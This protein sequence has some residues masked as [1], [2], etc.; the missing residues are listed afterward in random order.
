MRK[1]DLTGKVFHKLTVLEDTGEVRWK[2]PLW[3]CVCECGSTA[4]VT[5]REL[6]AGYVKSCGC[7]KYKSNPKYKEDLYKEW[8]YMKGRC[9][10]NQNSEFYKY[11]AGRGVRVCEEW[12]DDYEA[13]RE[14][15]LA[16]NYKEGLE[17]DRYPDR[18]GDYSPTNCRWV[19]HKENMRNTRRNRR[20][21]AFAESKA[22]S[23][24]SEE[25]DIN[26]S[27]LRGRIEGGWTTE[28]ALQEPVRQHKKYSLHELVDDEG[29]THSFAYWCEHYGISRNT[30]YTRLRQLK[31][32]VVEAFT[33][34]VDS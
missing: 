11:Y 23:V 16:N 27:T 15:S 22:M 17:L 1:L 7:L 8:R 32:T 18:D 5:T 33:T 6:K 25:F 31:W 14:W 13:F 4:L 24:W 20:L 2:S 26:A 9:T 10:T 19:P 30:V 3:K 21:D 29:K 12:I 28:Q 34:P